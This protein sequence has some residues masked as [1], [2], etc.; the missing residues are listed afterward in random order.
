MIFVFQKSF[1]L[2][3][4]MKIEFGW[5]VIIDSRVQLRLAGIG[6]LQEVG[7]LAFNISDDHISS[8]LR[9]AAIKY[10]M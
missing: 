2:F 3:H 7:E 6:L 10:I 8:L 5:P 1:F 9:Q 4:D